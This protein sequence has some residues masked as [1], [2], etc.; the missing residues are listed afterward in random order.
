M[1]RKKTTTPTTDRWVVHV[2]ETLAVLQTLPSESVDA[3]ITDPPYSSGG[4]TARE[5]AAL[6]LVSSSLR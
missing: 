4:R 2:G 1:T 3:V 6:L 5:R